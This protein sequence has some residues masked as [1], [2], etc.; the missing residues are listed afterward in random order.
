MVY[1]PLFTGGPEN[2][3]WVKTAKNRKSEKKLHDDL[4]KKHDAETKK[5]QAEKDVEHP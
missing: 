1:I 5:K 3:D 4:A 2:E